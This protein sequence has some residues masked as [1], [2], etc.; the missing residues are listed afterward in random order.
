MNTIDAT[1]TETTLPFRPT[2]RIL[3]LLGDELIA[4]PR[5]AVFE[6][7]KNAY[8][9]D[10]TT[11]TVKLNLSLGSSQVPSITITDDGTGMTLDTLESVWLVPGNDHRQ[12]QRK[13]LQRTSRH[14][15]LPIG[16]KGLGRFAAHKLG[17]RIT[18]VTR[19]QRNDECVVD[20]DWNELTAHQYLEDALVTITT[21]RP[22]FFTS[23]TTGTSIQIS[24]LRSEWSRGE[25]RRL[26]N[27]ITSICSPFEQRDDFRTVFEVPNHKNWLADLPNMAAVLDRAFWKFSFELKDGV[28]DWEYKFRQIP[29]LNL[30]GRVKHETDDKLLMKSDDQKS[31]GQKVIADESTTNGIGPVKG[32][33]YVYDRDRNI[34]RRL[35]DRQMITGYLDT[36]GGVRVYRDGIRVYNYGEQGDDWLGLDLRRVNTPTRRIS[37]NIVLGAIHLSL[38]HSSELIEKTN[39][40]GF[41][42]NAAY[43]RLQRLVMGAVEVCE[44]ERYIDKERIRLLSTSPKDPESSGIDG[45]LDTVR[46]ELDKLSVRNQTINSNLE[47]ISRYH[48]DMQERLLSAG[49]SGLNLAVLFHEIERG[50]KTLHR[51]LV[52]GTDVGRL[53]RQA[54]NLADTLDG[55][56]LLL[57]HSSNEQH[58]ARM[59][60]ENVL[61]ISSIRLD[62]HHIQVVPPSLVR[63]N[64]DFHFRFSFNITLGALSNLIDNALYWLRVRWPDTENNLQTPA[65]KLYV[66]VSREF[67]AGPA[68]VVADNGTGFQDDDLEY[69]ARPFFTRK[70]EGM[71]L[72]LYY[73]SL[74]MELQGGQLVFPR[75]GEV[76]IPDGLDGAAVAMIFKEDK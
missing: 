11:V 36:A 28:F 25:V 69:L 63:D 21:R 12:K 41:V 9:A 5:L 66:G 52:A 15:R 20:I 7:V 62:Y 54:E 1:T 34:L 35:P 16:E 71:G 72:G 49:L 70:P 23:E 14:N 32:E 19:A 50:V 42:D 4:N 44:T 26:H 60:I 51:S 55:F 57:R 27:Q 24:D 39:R 10:A 46:R 68:I 3:Q 22:T 61:Q 43:L 59:L 33:F 31:S 58:S 13:A 2:A 40:E 38:E 76:E 29:G 65:R 6:L 8:D 74:A 56:S 18:L 37:R 17:N 73:A 30:A 48:H 67:A 53:V 75:R 45:L 47:R 64:L